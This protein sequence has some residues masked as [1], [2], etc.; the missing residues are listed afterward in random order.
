ILIDGQDIAEVT[1]RSLRQ[2]ISYVPQEPLLFHRSL[3]ENIAYGLPGATE[4]QI[5]HAAERAY[6]LDFIESLPDGFETLVGERGVKLSGGQRQ[7]IAIAR[8]ILA[9]PKII[10]LDEAT[11]NLDT[12]SESLIQKSLNELMQGRTTFVIAHRLSTIRRASQILVIESG[13]IVERGNHQ[14]LIDKQG[15]YYE[16]YTYQARI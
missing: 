6:A 15:R 8:A 5:R 1:Q 10:I 9:D 12:E 13:R 14:E 4:D 16:L 7:R 3:R 11:S 2:Q